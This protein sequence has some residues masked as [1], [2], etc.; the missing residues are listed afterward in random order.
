MGLPEAAHERQ[1]GPE[2]VGIAIEFV[3]NLRGRASGLPG[4]RDK[5]VVAADIV[6]AKGDRFLLR[7]TET[8]IRTLCEAGWRREPLD[9]LVICRTSAIVH[10]ASQPIRSRPCANSPAKSAT[11]GPG[12]SSFRPPRARSA[13]D[14]RLAETTGAELVAR[15]LRGGMAR[16]S[17]DPTA[18]RAPPVPEESTSIAGGPTAWREDDSPD[19]QGKGGE[20]SGL[21]T[22]DPNEANRFLD[23]PRGA[24]RNQGVMDRDTLPRQ[25]LAQPQQS[26]LGALLA[27]ESGWV[28]AGSQSRSV[29]DAS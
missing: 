22:A 19:V 4:K 15:L 11:T 21:P 29:G 1:S 13:I 17:L 12:P 8:A 7:V 2:Q 3:Q 27:I 14:A 25:P 10:V 6:L 18:G 16:R 5:Q 9:L 24:Q 23:I 20:L 26:H 28:Q